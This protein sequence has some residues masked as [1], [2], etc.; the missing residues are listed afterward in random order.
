MIKNL[1]VA[2]IQLAVS[3]FRLGKVAQKWIMLG[4]MDS[5]IQIAD[6]ASLIMDDIL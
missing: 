3:A 6:R 4:V 2:R 1:I 5:Q